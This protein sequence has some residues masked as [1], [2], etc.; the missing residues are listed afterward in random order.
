LIDFENY[1]N[2][3]YKI[4]NIKNSFAFIDLK[5]KITLVLYKRTHLL[6]TDLSI[7]ISLEIEQ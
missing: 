1:S 4:S 2:Q 7:P 5:P 3:T 6:T